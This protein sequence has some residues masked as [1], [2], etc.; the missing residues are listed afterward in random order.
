[1]CSTVYN[2]DE[3]YTWRVSD[4]SPT[5]VMYK[6]RK[7]TFK[8]PVLNVSLQISSRLFGCSI[9]LSK[10]ADGNTTL[11]DRYI[12]LTYKNKY[13]LAYICIILTKWT[14]QCSCCSCSYLLISYVY[15]S[16]DRFACLCVRVMT[17]LVPNFLRTINRIKQIYF[18]LYHIDGIED[19]S[20]SCQSHRISPM[21]RV[22]LRYLSFKTYPRSNVQI[23]KYVLVHSLR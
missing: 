19:D 10:V 1:M 14:K 9:G 21:P 11:K 8:T 3:F 17:K 22:Y 16:D 23:T 20:E 6:I 4:S 2:W 13:I 15:I 5:H 7:L 12:P 18:I